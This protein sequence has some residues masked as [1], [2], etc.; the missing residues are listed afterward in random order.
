[1]PVGEENYELTGNTLRSHFEYTERGSTVALDATL[2]MKA[3]LTP[4][5]FEAHGRS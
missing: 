4:E 3:D 2:G 5:R 1:M